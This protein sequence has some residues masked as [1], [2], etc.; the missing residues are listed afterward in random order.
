MGMT[1]LVSSSFKCRKIGPNLH[2]E[3]HASLDPQ[4]FEGYMGAPPTV[5]V[6]S[7]I[8]ACVGVAATAAK[9]SAATATAVGRIESFMSILH[10]LFAPPQRLAN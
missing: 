5:T 8:C 7:F 1:V 3:V 10:V 6:C 2:V 9:T 4:L